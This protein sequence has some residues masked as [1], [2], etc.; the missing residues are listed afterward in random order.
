MSCAERVRLGALRHR[1][2]LPGPAANPTAEMANYVRYTNISD[3][4]FALQVDLCITTI[5][6]PVDLLMLGPN[7][8]NNL[9]PKTEIIAHLER[10]LREGFGDAPADTPYL[11]GYEAA[12]LLWKVLLESGF[13]SPSS[14][15][16]EQLI[17]L[18]KKANE[19]YRAGFL[20]ALV[21][22]NQDLSPVH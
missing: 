22:V 14:L 2:T 11:R 9:R 19:D 4:K 8:E 1:R 18:C 6:H 21:H 10:C 3:N 5:N 15:A 16:E 13:I 20:E 12:L 7:T 17:R